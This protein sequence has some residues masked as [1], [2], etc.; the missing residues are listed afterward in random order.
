MR[1]DLEHLHRAELLLVKLR[2]FGMVS[3]LAILAH[4]E[5]TTPVARIWAV[6]AGGFAYTALTYLHVRSGRGVRAG[7]IATTLGDAVLVASICVWT[8][9]LASDFYAYFYLT[10]IATSIRFG[11]GPAFAMC[12]VNSALSLALYLGAPAPAAGAAVPGD[13]ALRAF[14]LSFAATLGSALSRDARQNLAAARSARDRA[15][16]LSR[17]LIHAEEEERKRIA[18]ELHD[19]MGPRFFELYYGIDRARS[20][21]D[22]GKPD[23]AERLARLGADAR[24]C[25][26]EI[27]GLMNEL[28]P[29]V[30]DDFGV[31]EAL[32]EI[33]AAL[34][35][36]GELRVRLAIDPD[37][38][39]PRGEVNVALF[40]IAQEAV[41]NARKHAEAQELEL[42]LARDAHALVLTVRDDGCGFD[43]SRPAR[44]HF[45]L[46]T[47][48]ERA[49]AC[50]GRLELESAPGRG[51]TLRAIVPLGPGTP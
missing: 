18:G 20:A 23:A 44:G 25:G 50:G 1:S 5:R 24:E 3:W 41:L 21:V 22:A 51:T 49:E 33:G 11:A 43:S 32:R 36:Q 35:A 30:L 34:E 48:R 38:K 17:R 6:V 13:L 42:G 4:A 31:A 2:L 10:S 8:G 16:E 14:Y 7:A 27:R 45:G 15:R 40:R 26:D 12:A 37:A 46:H 47:M 39:A 19:R 9:G 29:S 28:R